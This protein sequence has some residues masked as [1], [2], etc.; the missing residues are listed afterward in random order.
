MAFGETSSA[1]WNGVAE[2][3]AERRVMRDGA[4]VRGPSDQSRWARAVDRSHQEA[5]APQ[6]R[7]R[8]QIKSAVV[9][10][11]AQLGGCG[12]NCTFAQ[13]GDGSGSGASRRNEV[14]YRRADRKP[15]GPDESFR[16]G[17]ACGRLKRARIPATTHRQPPCATLPSAMARVR[18]RAPNR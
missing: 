15:V 18:R 9:G 16:Q 8:A 3:L 12:D 6:L 4:I 10:K 11:S 17:A 14:I 7:S 13:T 1:Q 2:L 5:A